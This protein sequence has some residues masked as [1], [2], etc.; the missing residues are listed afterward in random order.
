MSKII[1]DAPC[2]EC[3]R[4]GR[5]RTG[6]HLMLF[7]DGG[8]F[9]NRCGYTESN[10]DIQ[11]NERPVKSPEEIQQE[12]EN[13]LEL[14]IL[15]IESRGL[16]L[17]TVQHFNVRTGLS[18]ADGSTPIEHYYPYG[19]RGEFT[20]CNVRV[21]EP[22]RFY[23]VGNRPIAEPFGIG[24]ARRCPNRKRIIIT[25]DEL[26]AMSVYQVF[27]QYTT[28][29]QWMPAVIGLTWSPQGIIDDLGRTEVLSF[30][31]EFDEIIFAL[32]NDDAGQQGYKDILQLI[33]EALTVS[34]PLKD[35]NDMLME[36][37]GLELYNLLRYH[38][39]H[40]VPEGSI[41]LGEL[42]ERILSP[43]EHGITYPWEHMTSLTL[44]FKTKQVISV[45]SGVG[46]GKTTF[47]NTL[48]AW[49]ADEHQ[50]KSGMVMLEQP[51]EETARSLL[52]SIL[53]RPLN[54]PTRGVVEELREAHRQELEDAIELVDDKFM[55]FDLVANT[56]WENV[57][58]VIHH[59]VVVEGVKIIF[60]DNLTTLTAHL[61]S[62]EINTEIGK[63]MSD[64]AAMVQRYD[65]TAFVFSHLNPP[66]SGKP[67]EEGGK[68]LE[69]QLTGSRSAM[70]YSHFVIGLE[71]NRSA[72]LPIDEQNKTRLRIMKARPIGSSPGLVGLE[73][74]SSTCRFYQR[75]NSNIGGE[76]V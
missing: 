69:V 18:V 61:S 49:F 11:P 51:A 6:N 70:R 27:D 41:T 20:S 12:L 13:V 65:F 21:L 39:K 25:E 52:G 26:S 4:N 74:R 22:K 56:E 33:P 10:T 30:L 47:A 15:A 34:L 50:L 35:P 68:V 59:W 75:D 37:M 32:D 45:A 63:I 57:K 53:E 76:E 5:D 43:V 38:A 72:D 64:L 62:S 7:E 36:G 44:G 42:K 31:N 55:L 2:P 14:P 66:Q 24:L 60:L 58:R 48:A 3:R 28:D 54:D 23:G 1:G 16:T 46:L 40:K 67:H 73:Y 8:A 19:T 29:K 71:R 9:C 17:A